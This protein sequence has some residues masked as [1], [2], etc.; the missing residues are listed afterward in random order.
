MTKPPKNAKIILFFLLKR[1]EGG[2]NVSKPRK[3]LIV[4]Q[5]ILDNDTLVS[6]SASLQIK[7]AVEYIQ[8]KSNM[9]VGEFSNGILEAMDICDFYFVD[10]NNQTLY[11]M[12]DSIDKFKEYIKKIKQSVP[13]K[14]A[15][16]TYIGAP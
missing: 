7:E 13:L 15:L 10:V 3:I 2:I 8:P 12:S 9:T 16:A 1:N 4:S 14:F 11:C 6:I 5:T